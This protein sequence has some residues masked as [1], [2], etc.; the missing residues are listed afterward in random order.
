[1]SVI[2]DTR[3]LTL[4]VVGNVDKTFFFPGNRNRVALNISADGN[5]LIERVLFLGPVAI[6]GREYAWLK[7]NEHTSLPYRDWGPVIKEPVYIGLF[8]GATDVLVT[9]TFVIPRR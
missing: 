9:E 4:N 1:M 7:V 5:P 2:Y 3:S 8:L 6:L